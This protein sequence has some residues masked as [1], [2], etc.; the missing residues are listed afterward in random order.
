MNSSR[1]ALMVLIPA[2]ILMVAVGEVESAPGTRDTGLLDLPLPEIL[3]G[4]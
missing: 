4:K 1:V 2:V 3:R